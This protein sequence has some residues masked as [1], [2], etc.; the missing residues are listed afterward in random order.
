MLWWLRSIIEKFHPLLDKCSLTAGE[1]GHESWSPYTFRA[2]SSDN[3]HAFIREGSLTI[4]LKTLPRRLKLGSIFAISWGPSLNRSRLYYESVNCLL[5]SYNV[6]FYRYDEMTS[7]PAF[8]KKNIQNANTYL[9]HSSPEKQNSFVTYHTLL[10]L[11]VVFGLAILTTAA[12]IGCPIMCTWAA[13][14]ICEQ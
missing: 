7:N 9:P 14:N 10:S 3:S 2:N 13:A 4:S 12:P 5:F 6:P 1:R 11:Y 8:T